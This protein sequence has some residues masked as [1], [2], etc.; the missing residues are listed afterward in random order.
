MSLRAVAS[1]ARPQRLATSWSGALAGACLAP[2][3][4]KPALVAAVALALSLAHLGGAALND[5]Y[6]APLDALLRPRRPIPSGELPRG[7][8]LALGYGALAGFVFSAVVLA[9]PLGARGGAAAAGIALVLA[10]TV[11]LY[12]TAHAGNPAAP[13]L[14]AV[15]RGLIYVTASVVVSGRLSGAPALGA[16]VLAAYSVGLSCVC[17]REDGGARLWPLLLLFSPLVATAPLLAGTSGQACLW[18]CALAWIARGA[19]RLLQR[20]FSRAWISLFSAMPLI[21][22]LL[23]G[24]M[25]LRPAVWV[26]AAAFPVTYLLLRFAPES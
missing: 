18:F 15:C 8:A 1:L 14:L 23:I 11:V 17:D 25:G 20:D 19:L 26:A 16:A 2:A 6:D 3:E 5:A 12:D 7:A 4:G 21:D 10:G 22:A 13:A 9:L 24:Q